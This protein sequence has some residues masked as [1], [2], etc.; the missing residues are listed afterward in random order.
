MRVLV[1]SDSQLAQLGLGA[2]V[3][4][5]GGLEVVA[6]VPPGGAAEA[7][8]QLGPEAIL[9]DAGGGG[10]SLQ[11]MLEVMGDRNGIP[12]LVLGD[13]Q[14]AGDAIAAGAAG[15]LPAGVGPDVLAAA[16]GAAVSGLVV[17][18]RA[19]AESLAP[20]LVE[21]D[22]ATQPVEQLTLR[23]SQVLQLL[24]HG[25]TN[26]EI[27]RSLGVSEHTAKFH[28][29]TV[30]GKLGARSRAEAV[31]LGMRLGWITV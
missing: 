25:L 13:P 10:S 31:L 23:E 19:Q 1:V 24:G 2:L 4:Q 21:G 18:G 8:A 17:L 20:G 30:L 6:A 29:G 15:V 3:E 12:L 11:E 14:A 16:I 7:I 27:G 22:E 26:A 28:V 5:A 9:L